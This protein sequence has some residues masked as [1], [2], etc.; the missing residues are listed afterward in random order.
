M[1]I[2]GCAWP[3]AVVIPCYRV[4]STITDVVSRIGP[5]VTW[6]IVVDDGCPEK[7]GATVAAEISD[8]RVRVLFHKTNQGVG[9]A[10]RTG[11]NEA[12]TLG[13]EVIVK[14]DGD[15]QMAPEVIGA[16]IEPIMTGAADYTKGNRLF[17]I[18]TFRQMPAVRLF[19]NIMLTFLTKVSSGYWTV[20]DPTCG[21]TAISASVAKRIPLEKISRGYF[22]E[23]DLLFRL[24]L[25]RAVVLD[26]PIDAIYANER[27]NLSIRKEVTR[28]LFG[29]LKNFCKRVFYNYF[30][31]DFNFAS[32]QLALS[33]CFLLFGFIFGG[34]HWIEYA[35]MD[36]LASSG[37]VML[38]ALPTILGTQL[39]VGFVNFDMAN[40]PKLPI[41]G[42]IG[43][44]AR[45]PSLRTKNRPPDVYI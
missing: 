30:L 34:L 35:R 23:S 5:E 39:L 37:T 24:N 22:F 32:I 10:V 27:S 21:Y 43:W 1:K 12:L 31:R 18:D 6:I 13:A 14:I 40:S 45:K 25:L 36:V 33:I 19:G 15:G 9:A 42:R 29:N 16:F 7:S 38:A 2:K 17:E 26:I 4:V 44:D 41:Q 8:V 3:V 20:A 11:Y 28:F